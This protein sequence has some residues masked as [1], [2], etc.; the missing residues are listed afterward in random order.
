VASFLK[1]QGSPGLGIRQRV[2][3][4]SERIYRADRV[5]VSSCGL[6]S[7]VGSPFN[8][9]LASGIFFL[10][11]FNSKPKVKIKR[12]TEL[13]VPYYT[14]EILYHRHLV[15]TRKNDHRTPVLSQGLRQKVHTRRRQRRYSMIMMRTTVVDEIAQLSLSSQVV[16]VVGDGLK[17][18]LNFK[19]NSD[20]K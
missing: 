3:P 4:G 16:K 8:L 13:V 7:F 15:I 6:I 19:S 5:A 9:F 2:K 20:E 12:I 18:S 10:S 1:R 11:R 17:L 14:L